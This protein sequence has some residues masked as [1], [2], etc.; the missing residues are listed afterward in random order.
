MIIYE[1][2]QKTI[3]TLLAISMIFLLSTSVTAINVSKFPNQESISYTS[4]DILPDGGKDYT[5]FVNGIENHYF[6]PPEDF[7][8]LTAS[9]AELAM[10]Y[11]PP[12][13]D[14]NDKASYSEW[15]D[16]MSNYTGT[17]EPEGMVSSTEIIIEQN[18]LSHLC[19]SVHGIQIFGLDMNLIWA[20]PVLNFILKYKWIIHNLL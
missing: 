17:P 2:K 18:Q 3:A 10:Y 6:V 4:V 19:L 9:D 11:F 7:N 20:P 8:P 1:V 14:T 15:I 5:Y 12:R 13:P 16:V